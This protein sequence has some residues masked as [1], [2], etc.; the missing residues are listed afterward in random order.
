MECN[1]LIHN[2]KVFGLT[3]A[4]R[5]SKYQDVAD[6]VTATKTVTPTTKFLGGIN[7]YQIYI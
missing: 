2:V 1:E 5:R 7:S 3:D 6:V 4:V